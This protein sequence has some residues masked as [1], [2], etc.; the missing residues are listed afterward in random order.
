MMARIPFLLIALALWLS[1]EP[2]SAFSSCPQPNIALTLANDLGYDDAIRRDDTDN[3]FT[4]KAEDFLR[5]HATQHTGQPFFLNPA[6]HAVHGPL[7]P[8]ANLKDKS[9]TGLDG[10]AKTTIGQ[11]YHLTNDPGETSD[12]WEKHPEIVD[13][14]RLRLGAVM[15]QGR[16][17]E[18]P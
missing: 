14:L 10:P 18:L 12:L 4:S 3:L 2:S 8:L 6:L 9:K 1:V 15:Q 13:R 17:R 7:T 16:T 11:L 5:K